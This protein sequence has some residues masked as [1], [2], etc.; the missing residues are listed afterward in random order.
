MRRENHIQHIP[1][2]IRQIQ[3]WALYVNRVET[4][5]R[6]YVGSLVCVFVCVCDGEGA[7]KCCV[8]HSKATALK[9]AEEF[10]WC[11]GHVTQAGK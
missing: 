8:W 5:K 10:I 6:L 1:D 7:L 9:T 3:Y 4:I 2:F 11:A